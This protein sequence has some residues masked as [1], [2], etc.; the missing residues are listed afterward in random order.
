[1]IESRPGGV[2]EGDRAAWAQDAVSRLERQIRKAYFGQPE[3]VWGLIIGLLARGNVL[4][5]GAPGLGKTLLVRV[6]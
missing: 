4:L 1:L 3:L 5:E 6:V 2:K